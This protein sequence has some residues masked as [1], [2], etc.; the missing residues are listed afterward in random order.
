MTFR[1][2]SGDEAPLLAQAGAA[3]DRAVVH[4]HP[5]PNSAAAL[6]S[7]LCTPVGM[8]APP[9]LEQPPIEHT[10]LAHPRSTVGRVCPTS[11]STVRPRHRR[12][13]IEA[14]EASA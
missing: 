1:R 13:T 2:G 7:R 3:V 12:R 10:D 8:N 11:T 14:S 4:F 6:N 9:A 5:P